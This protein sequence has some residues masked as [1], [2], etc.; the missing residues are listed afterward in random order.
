MPN[1]KSAVDAKYFDAIDA[2]QDIEVNSSEAASYG[3]GSGPDR[4][5]GYTFTHKDAAALK[6][7]QG[8]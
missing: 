2:E 7:M 5:W 1:L 3:G 6:K 8:E 4:V